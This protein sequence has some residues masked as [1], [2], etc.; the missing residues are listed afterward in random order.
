MERILERGYLLLEDN[1]IFIDGDAFIFNNQDTPKLTG[2]GYIYVYVL[3]NGKM[4]VGQTIDPKRR[5]AEHLRAKSY[6]GRAVRKHGIECLIY[7]PNVSMDDIDKVEILF[8]SS[9]KTLEPDGYNLTTGGKGN[10]NF[11]RTTKE[12][13]HLNAIER[14]FEKRGY[15]GSVYEE[16]G[17]FRP[18]I[19]WGG[20]RV[21]LSTGSF[22]TNE[23]AVDVLFSFTK[24]ILEDGGL[25]ED[26]KPVESPRLNTSEKMRCS[27]YQ[28]MIYRNGR[29]GSVVPKD[30]LFVPVVGWEMGVFRPSTGGF[31]SWNEADDVLLKVTEHYLEHGNL[32]NFEKIISPLRTDED[33]EKSYS[34]FKETWNNKLI[35]K[36]GRIGYVHSYTYDSGTTL[37]YPYYRKGRC[38]EKNRLSVGGFETYEEADAVL[39]DATEWIQSGNDIKSFKKVV[40]L[41]LPKHNSTSKE[42]MSRIQIERRIKENGRLGFVSVKKG[43]EIIGYTP[44]CIINHERK[45]L[46]KGGTCRTREYANQILMDASEYYREHGNLDNFPVVEI[47]LREETNNRKKNKKIGQLKRAINKNGYIGSVKIDKRTKH[48][49]YHPVVG[50]TPQISLSIGGVET[51]DEAINILK[52]ATEWYLSGKKIEDFP[53]VKGWSDPRSRPIE[54]KLHG[55]DD[56]WTTWEGNVTEFAKKLNVSPGAV[57]A[58]LKEGTKRIQTGGYNVRRVQN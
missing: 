57:S 17:L 10:Y 36:N 13:F 33:L 18:V 55:S 19:Y 30:G 6:F 38:G 50:A 35:E 12:V 26:F 54:Y 27:M 23:E 56:P 39:K 5:R 48:I 47:P 41:Y 1:N 14:N 22:E 2:C 49:L 3:N 28:T 9:F 16:H 11:S 24:F 40:S 53:K 34:K 32:E 52:K 42:V 45:Q 7:F 51:E 46:T 44:V 25:L 29:I 31:K 4:Y 37:H 43:K 58:V 15:F 8:I 21:P 20:P